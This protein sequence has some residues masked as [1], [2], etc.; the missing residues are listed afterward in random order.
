MIIGGLAL[1]VFV[2]FINGAASAAFRFSTPS[3]RVGRKVYGG[4]STHLPMKVNMSGVLPI[5]F[6]Q[7]I[8]SLPITIWSFIGDSTGWHGLPFHL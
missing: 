1:M 5:I 4:R 3:V 2:V 7:S 8:A 6:A